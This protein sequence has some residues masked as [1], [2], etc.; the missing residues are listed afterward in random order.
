MGEPTR[1]VCPSHLGIKVE[2]LALQTFFVKHCMRMLIKEQSQDR[3]YSP[4]A[5]E[6]PGLSIFLS[7]RTHVAT[8]FADLTP[9]AF[10]ECVVAA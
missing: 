8:G 1:V 3:S 6:R 4:R 10:Y 5:D 2:P 9:I 7:A